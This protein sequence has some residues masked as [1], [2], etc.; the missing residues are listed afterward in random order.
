MSAEGGQPQASTQ[1]M[2]PPDPR[3]PRPPETLVCTLPRRVSA[4]ARKAAAFENPESC[5]LDQGM[6][7][8]KVYPSLPAPSL[9]R[10]VHS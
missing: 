5:R 1:P 8:G 2:S 3:P 4:S 9:P 7:C 10:P 6:E